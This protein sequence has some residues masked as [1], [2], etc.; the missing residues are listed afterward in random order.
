MRPTLRTFLLTVLGLVTVLMI[1]I[2]AI[3]KAES[4]QSAQL[5]A[6]SSK[7][8]SL[9]ADKEINES[10]GIVLSQRNENC[11]WTHNDSGDISR[12]FLVHRDGRSIA[13]FRVMGVK[14]IDWEDIAMATIGD[15]EKIII[16]DIGGNSQS[17][18]F[19]SLYFVTEPQFEFDAT[20]STTPIERSAMVETTI[21]VSFSGRVTNYEGI[22]V[23]RAAKLI[24]IVEKALFGAR[25]YTV[26]LPTPADLMKE[27]TDVV[28]KEIGH[29][30]IPYAC[31]CD[32]SHDDKS[33]VI[34]NYTLGYLFSRQSLA[35]GSFEDWSETLKR[36]P[37]AFKLP[38]LK[39]PEAACFSKDDQS[40]FLTSEQLP[41][42]LVEMILPLAK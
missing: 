18:K 34:T 25:V 4:L 30:N 5:P 2:I 36:E 10:S 28:A 23:D 41:T 17:R 21:Q 35:D 3:P 7:Q 16:A 8:I 37:V 33:L 19:V 27:K 40:L 29:T 1:S 12:L 22:A 11:F 32:I 42:P 26:P 38:K 6:S 13:R 20:K 39:Q 14:P 24:L 15:S 9:L 31:A